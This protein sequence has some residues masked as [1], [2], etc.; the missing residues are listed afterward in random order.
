MTAQT[1][2]C[3]VD[4]RLLRVSDVHGPGVFAAIPPLL[5]RFCS[6][7]ENRAVPG[8]RPRLAIGDRLPA[9]VAELHAV[10]FE[11]SAP[12]VPTF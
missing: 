11:Q 5:E 1:M 7:T 2:I 4:G 12:R 8:S 9:V 10:P 3:P 6:T